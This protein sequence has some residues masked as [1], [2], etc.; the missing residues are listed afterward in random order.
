MGTTIQYVLDK[1]IFVK[2]LD[3]IALVSLM[4]DICLI[5]DEITPEYL[6]QASGIV[7]TWQVDLAGSGPGTANLRLEQLVTSG[8]KDS[9]LV[10]L[11][12]VEQ[13]LDTYGEKVP[14]S[15]LSKHCRVWGIEFYGYP[16]ESLKET[17]SKIRQLLIE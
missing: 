16:A 17:I 5:G 1:R 4:E 9:L 14:I 10:L 15:I 6:K 7:E 11:A 3:L 13:R 12:A 2:D 8:M